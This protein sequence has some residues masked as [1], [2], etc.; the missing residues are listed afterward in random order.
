MIC[1][2]MDCSGTLSSCEQVVCCLCIGPTFDFVQDGSQ[3]MCPAFD[4]SAWI[5][6]LEQGVLPLHRP[7]HGCYAKDASLVMSGDVSCQ[8]GRYVVFFNR[9][10]LGFPSATNDAASLA[11]LKSYTRSFKFGAEFLR[12]RW[13]GQLSDVVE[14]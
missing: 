4:L 12:D 10:F 1:F 5:P 7:H 3:H 14:D 11:N 2:G 9:P 6:P 13:S 8:R